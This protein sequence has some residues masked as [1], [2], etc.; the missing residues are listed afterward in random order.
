MMF[1]LDRRKNSNANIA[2]SR[3]QVILTHERGGP[4]STP[5]YL[6]ALQAEVIAVIS[7]YVKIAC[8]DL[9]VNFDWQ[10]GLEVFEVKIEIPLRT[11][12]YLSPMQR[13]LITVTSKY[14]TPPIDIVVNL[15]RQGDLE[16][17]QV[18]IVVPQR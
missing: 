6:P 11:D 10:N 17:L 2:K 12:D 7:R 18:K 14:V 5:H 9:K 15:E 13:E 8:K 1:L 3:L 16:V 4:N